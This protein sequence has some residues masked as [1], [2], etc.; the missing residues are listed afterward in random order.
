LA[1]GKHTKGTINNQS[2]TDIE[3]L[4]Y[5]MNVDYFLKKTKVIYTPQDYNANFNVT[6][7]LNG[8]KKVN[9]DMVLKLGFTQSNKEKISVNISI[10]NTNSYC[11]HPTMP[12]YVS[13]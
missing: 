11:L 7:N 5:N 10:C 4:G 9:L 1:R 13:K 3:S 8:K 2:F 6:L 12:V